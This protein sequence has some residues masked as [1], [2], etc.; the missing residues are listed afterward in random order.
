MTK[1]YRVRSRIL[2]YR[3]GACKL[4]TPI[5]QKI[6]IKTTAAARRRASGIPRVPLIGDSLPIASRGTG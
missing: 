4:T 2:A 3:T 5:N 1:S 6:H